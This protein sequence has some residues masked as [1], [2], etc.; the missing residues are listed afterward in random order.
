MRTLRP[1]ACWPLGSTPFPSLVSPPVSTTPR[2][3]Q[4]LTQAA[5]LLHPRDYSAVCSLLADC[6]AGVNGQV[7]WR[8]LSDSERA[9]YEER[10]RRAV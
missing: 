8:G 7:L 3:T 5:G 9:L 6:T 2:F 4:T 1:T 10:A